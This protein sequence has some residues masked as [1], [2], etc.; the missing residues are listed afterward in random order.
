MNGLLDFSTN[1]NIPNFKKNQAIIRA[2]LPAGRQGEK[3]G[4]GILNFSLATPSKFI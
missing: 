3:Q 2:P 4:E 1:F